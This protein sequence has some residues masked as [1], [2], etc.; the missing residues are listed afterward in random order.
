MNISDVPLSSTKPRMHAGNYV[1]LAGEFFVLGELALRRLDG[2]LTLGHTKEIDILVLNRET[3]RTFKVEV[4]TST[5][6]RRTSSIFGAAYEWMMD[7]RHGRLEAPD[8]VY[9][10]VRLGRE[11]EERTFFLVPSSDVAAYIRW[12]FQHWKSHSTRRT[13]KTSSLRT[14]RMPQGQPKVD[15]LP[16]SWRDERWRRWEGNW[17]IFGRLPSKPG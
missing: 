6:P 13:G 17:A 4:K 10:F 3:A 15:A 16:P 14:F 11:P 12:E 9:A 2:T 8:L 5:K 7:E 1:T